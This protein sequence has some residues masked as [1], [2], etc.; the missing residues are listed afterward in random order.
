MNKIH[1]DKSKFAIEYTIGE[2]RFGDLIRIWVNDK[3]FGS[4]KV[5]TDVDFVV[6][7]LSQIYEIRLIQIP[8]NYIGRYTELFKDLISNKINHDH[9]LLDLGDAFDD[10]IIYVCKRNENAVFLWKKYDDNAEIM[11]GEVNIEYTREVLI[12]FESGKK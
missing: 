1:G 7:H 4:F 11:F 10:H 6:Y 5:E 3:T 8:K 12:S 2:S 9:F